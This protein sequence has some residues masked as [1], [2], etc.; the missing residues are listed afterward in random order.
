M[1][2]AKSYGAVGWGVV[3]QPTSYK[4]LRV[5]D[6]G[7]TFPKHSHLHRL[8]VA[9]KA[10]AATLSDGVPPDEIRKRFGIYH[11]VST[12]ARIAERKAEELIGY[13][14]ERFGAA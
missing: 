3:E 5:G 12:S 7:D 9:W 11:P 2:Y 14:S 6:P 8:S 4:L 13:L 1:A 10:T